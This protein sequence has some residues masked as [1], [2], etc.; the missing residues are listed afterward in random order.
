MM[1][2]IHHRLASAFFLLQLVACSQPSADGTTDDG[3]GGTD[4]TGG[5]PFVPISDLDSGP[6]CDPFTQD[7]PDGEK[8][9]PYASSGTVWD[10]NMCVP[11]TG[12]GAIG[13]TCISAGI[14]E[15]T[16]DCGLDSICWDVMDID[17]VLT[18]VCTPFCAGTADVPICDPGSSCMIAS[19]G[20]ITLCIP[21]CDPLIQDCGDA[22]GCYFTGSDFNC[23]FTTSN[24]PMGEPCGYINDCAPGNFCA[25]ATSLAVCDGSA[26]CALFCNLVDPLCLLA[27]TECVAFFD[28]GMAPPGHEDVGVCILPP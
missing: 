16:D 18:G 23:V 5:P 2:T 8:C 28:E 11:V 27:Q 4:T 21:T 13:D 26:C 19:D 9:V 22:L 20:S 3:T 1:I 15:A 17:G 7:C 6:V 10:A 25:D 24:I 12:D 14:V